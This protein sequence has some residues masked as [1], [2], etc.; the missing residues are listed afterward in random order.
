[1]ADRLLI[2]GSWVDSFKFPTKIQ[3][4]GDVLTTVKSIVCVCVCA[5]VCTCICVC[6]GVVCGCGCLPIRSLIFPFISN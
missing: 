6:G 3:C 5:C 4:I 2:I 1:M